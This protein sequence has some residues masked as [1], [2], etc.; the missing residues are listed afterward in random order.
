MYITTILCQVI[1]FPT[2]NQFL[3]GKVILVGNSSSLIG[4][5]WS[6][7]LFSHQKCSFGRKTDHMTKNGC[8]VHLCA[9]VHQFWCT[10]MWQ[11]HCHGISHGVSVMHNFPID[12]PLQPFGLLWYIALA[13]CTSLNT[14]LEIPWQL[15]FTQ[16][17][18]W[19]G[20]TLN[21]VLKGLIYFGGQNTSKENM[22]YVLNF[23]WFIK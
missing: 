6:C 8:D 18:T 4:W 14:L 22:P 19:N 9:G 2:K 20:S 1:Y 10:M 3:A 17:K 12:V 21:L 15:V 23:L 16:I 5:Y 13:C 7:D 11:N